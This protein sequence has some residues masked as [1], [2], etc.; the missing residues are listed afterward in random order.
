MTQTSK[1]LLVFYCLFQKLVSDRQNNTISLSLPH[2]PSPTLPCSNQKMLLPQTWLR[3]KRWEVSSGLPGWVQW[4]P[5][6]SSKRKVIWQSQRGEVPMATKGRRQDQGSRGRSR[7]HR[8]RELPETA[9]G[10]Q[11]S[12]WKACCPAGILN[13][14]LWRPFCPPHSKME[15]CCFKSLG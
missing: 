10:N 9:K 11:W 6:S 12:L 5:K 1:E 3:I 14:C 8:S 7:N 15:L 4:T 2:L 13:F